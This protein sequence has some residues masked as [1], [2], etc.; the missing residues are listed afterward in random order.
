[1]SS[2]NG[3]C[4]VPHGLKVFWPRP[5]ASCMIPVTVSRLDCLGLRRLQSVAVH[6]SVHRFP[7]HDMDAEGAP[8]CT[9]IW[10]VRWNSG[11][12]T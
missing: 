3:S 5:P 7:E 4:D 2:P 11:T 8:G 6:R 1:M 10:K 9:G 12:G